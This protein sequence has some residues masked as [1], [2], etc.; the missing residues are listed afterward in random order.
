MTSPEQLKPPSEAFINPL[1]ELRNYYA[2]LVQK[3]QK[4]F[5][6]ARS[7][8]DHVEAL[9]SSWSYSDDHEPISELEEDQVSSQLFLASNHQSTLESFA[10]EY[11]EHKN[12][13]EVCPETPEPIT[14][15]IDA[16]VLPPSE[17]THKSFGKGEEVPMIAQY[18]SLNRME[19]LRLFFDEH[20]GTACHI[21]FILRSLYGNLEPAVLKIVKGRLQ[22][23]LTQGREKGDWYAVPN[24]PGCYTLALNLLD[25]SRRSSSSAGHT[26]KK[27]SVTASA[28]PSTIIP[29]LEQFE[30]Q[31]LIDAISLFLEQHRG[32][33]F[34]VNE[35]IQGIYGNLDDQQ[36]ARIKNKTLNELSRGHR[37]GRF[38]RVPNQVG[39]YT[40]NA[41]LLPRDI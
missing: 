32:Q 1:L 37:T 30:G 13:K 23:S 33:I 3:Y 24:E 35:V 29:V 2:S 21:D 4:L 9:L 36:I 31:F 18:K 26:K 8:L 41:N 16:T 6:E 38:S 28:S 15:A 12:Q 5:I 11:L 40:W 19:A 39:F 14:D 10:S 34:T 25:Y 17:E 27:K 20:A 22:S 7:Q